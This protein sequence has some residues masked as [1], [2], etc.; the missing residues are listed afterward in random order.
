MSRSVHDHER[1]AQRRAAPLS[2]NGAAVTAEHSH[3][4]PPTLTDDPT[5]ARDARPSRGVILAHDDHGRALDGLRGFAQ[6]A[7]Y[8]GTGGVGRRRRLDGCCDALGGETNR[9][10]SDLA[11]CLL[12]IG[13]RLGARPRAGRWACAATALAPSSSALVSD[14]CA[15]VVELGGAPPRLSAAGGSPIADAAG[16]W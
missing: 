5:R 16:T 11:A 10:S 4:P 3:L 7:R 9:L 15:A 2:Q 12:D 8:V 1:R 13:R 14:C 6:R